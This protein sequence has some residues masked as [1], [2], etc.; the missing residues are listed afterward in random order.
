[1]TR[2]GA[3]NPRIYQLANST[4]H[5]AIFQDVTSGNNSFH[6]VSGYA[7]GPGFDLATGWGTV[8]INAL[9]TTFFAAVTPLGPQVL[10]LSPATLNFGNVDF[11][12]AG[13]ANKVKKLTITNP[14]KYE[15][16]L[17]IDSIVGSAGFTADSSCNNVTI[18]PGGKLVCSITYTPT[19]FGAANGTLTITSNAG[20]SPQ[21]V[22]VTGVGILGKLT[23]TPGSLNF[24]KV[25][26]STASA[27]KTVTLKNTTGSTFTDLEHHQHQSGLRPEP[28]L[29]RHAGRGR[30]CR[31][32]DLHAERGQQG[33][34]HA[35]DY[36]RAGRH[37]EDRQPERHGRIDPNGTGERD[38][39]SSLFW[40]RVAGCFF[41]NA[42]RRLT[43]SL[44]LRLRWRAP[45]SVPPARSILAAPQRDQADSIAWLAQKSRDIQL[46]VVLDHLV[47]TEPR[48]TA[49]ILARLALEGR[50]I[51]R[52]V[53][54]DHPETPHR[55]AEHGVLRR[56]R[57][58]GGSGGI[59]AVGC[60]ISGSIGRVGAAST[61]AVNGV[62]EGV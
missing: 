4:S 26:L 30:L 15:A 56:P 17:L 62:P 45:C 52:A 37:Y 54:H 5:G 58:D 9:A 38:G 13:A 44:R 2:L 18:P 51:Q 36:R 53:V 21:A 24:G 31:E 1:M 28:E 34:R 16:E 25:A 6:K 22:A 57:R 42:V 46:V 59:T 49:A 40:P 23:A 14:K 29:R 55:L 3:L 12:V 61:G 10:T 33:D 41:L 32:C 27:A 50:N 11:A 48:R 8:D 47:L 35:D 60:G 20:T 19:A 43:C 39:R 7:A